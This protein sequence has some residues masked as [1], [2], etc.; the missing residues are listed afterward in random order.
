[1]GLVDGEGDRDN[2]DTADIR[3]PWLPTL[4]IR[5]L[6][7]EIHSNAATSELAESFR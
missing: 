4:E 1:M 7:P 2:A 3:D 5:L 6:R